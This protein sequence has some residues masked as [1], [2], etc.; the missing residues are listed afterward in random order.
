MAT[1]NNTVHQLEALQRLIVS[2]IDIVKENVIQNNDPPLIL[3]ALEEHPIHRR[4]DPAL[5]R[6]LKTTSSA[7]EMLKALCDPNTFINDITYGVSI[8]CPGL[9]TR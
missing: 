3:Q 5:A 7:A 9:N 8:L 1:Q 4:N 2:S 6:A